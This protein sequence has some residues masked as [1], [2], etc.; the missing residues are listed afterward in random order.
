MSLAMWTRA[1]DSV[2][3]RRCRGTFASSAFPAGRPRTQTNRHAPIDRFVAVR[4]GGIATGD[5]RTFR[6]SREAAL[7]QGRS[8]SDNGRSTASIDGISSLAGDGCSGC[9]SLGHRSPPPDR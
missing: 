1:G 4:A 5:R 6:S 2:L 9:D 3:L 8:V 7:K